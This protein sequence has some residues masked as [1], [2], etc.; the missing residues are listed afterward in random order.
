[1]KKVI[2]AICA[3]GLLVSNVGAQKILKQPIQSVTKVEAVGL[4]RENIS[5]ISR[6]DMTSKN[7]LNLNKAEFGK[8]YTSVPLKK[9]SS[10]VAENVLLEED[11]EG[12]TLSGWGRI[13][14]DN[15]T[16]AADNMNIDWTQGWVW[17]GITQD[18]AGYVSKTYFT[19]AGTADRWLFSSTFTIPNDANSYTAIWEATSIFDGDENVYEFR[20]IEEEKFQACL[21]SW[22][23]AT[24]LA[25]AS[26]QL[27]N[28]SALLNTYKETQADFYERRIDIDS[29]KGKTAR[30]VWRNISSDGYYLAIDN[31]VVRQ[32]SEYEASLSIYAPIT[33]YTQLPKSWDLTTTGVVTAIIENKGTKPLTNIDLELNGYKGETT[34]FSDTITL[35]SLAVNKSDTLSSKRFYFDQSSIAESYYFDATLNSEEGAEGYVASETVLGPV[36]SDS[37]VALDNGV[38]LR[39]FAVLMDTDKVLGSLFY[40]P[41]KATL[42]SVTFKY[43]TSTSTKTRARIFKVGSAITEVAT[44]DYVNINTTLTNQEVVIPISLNFDANTSYL[45]TLEEAANTSLGIILT[46]M[47]N[48]NGGWTNFSS[49][50]SASIS[51]W[52]SFV[53]TQ[54][55]YI[56][57]NFKVENIGIDTEEGQT[58][59]VSYAND[60]LTV[61]GAAIGSPVNVYTVSGTS[62]A[63]ASVAS[64]SDVVAKNLAAGVYIV[65]VGNKTEKVLVK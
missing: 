57:A 26:A 62:V 21:D 46:T 1:M 42:S 51:N 56:R 5:G 64:D 45:V 31:V 28:N 14:L 63:V 11:F 20:I 17:M 52:Y 50:F 15:M 16:V 35:A 65:K 10:A 38:T 9:S 7:V 37:T 53:A 47:D 36:L 48:D 32:K 25:E 39:S 30:I 54:S 22:T 6:K 61:S 24:T 58:V 43:G 8:K 60:K 40:L 27:Q 4:E 55:L 18:N 13:T 12:Q 29:Y 49:P 44:S 34:V 19:E 33:A 59:N 23:D 41:V 2:L 3:L